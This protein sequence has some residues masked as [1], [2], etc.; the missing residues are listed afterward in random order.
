MFNTRFL[1]YVFVNRE[2]KTF[3]GIRIHEREITKITAEELLN[4]VVQGCSDAKGRDIKVLNVSKVFGLASYFVIVSGRSDRQSQGICNRVLDSLSDHEISPISVDGLED[5][6]WVLA[7]LGDVMLHVFYEPI[8]EY[9]NLEGLWATA[10]RVEFPELEQ[11]E[12]A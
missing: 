1:L 3:G 6:Q 7:D 2:T 12:A 11:K 10:E 9:Y 4:L 5:G 8:R